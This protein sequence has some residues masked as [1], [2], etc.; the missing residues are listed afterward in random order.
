MPG[1][2]GD[3]RSKMSDREFYLWLRESLRRIILTIDLS[4]KITW[5][6]N[7]HYLHASLRRNS[8][9]RK[10][11][12]SLLTMAQESPKTPASMK[13]AVRPYLVHAKIET[14]FTKGQRDSKKTRLHRQRVRQRRLKQDHQYKI[15]FMAQCCA[16]S[17]YRRERLTDT[18][19]KEL[20]KEGTCL[21][22][23]DFPP[24]IVETKRQ[25]IRLLRAVKGQ[26]EN[27]GRNS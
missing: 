4:G 17:R 5:H 11:Y 12:D 13:L 1:E 19:I 25:Q 27:N 21:K 26:H 2:I 6:W 3:R 23:D 22:S 14:D 10:R 20:L 24:E 9:Q 18:Y 8:R 15:R 16:A 7:S